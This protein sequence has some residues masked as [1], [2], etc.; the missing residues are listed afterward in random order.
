[1]DGADE[2]ESP[3]RLPRRRRW[4][5]KAAGFLAAFPLLAFLASNLWLASAWG[6]G[7]MAAKVKGVT[8]LETRIAGASWSPWNGI[9][10]H[11]IVLE[12][13]AALRDPAATPLVAIES[14]RI[15]P[16]W[17]SWIHR[18][19]ELKSVEIDRPQ[20]ILPVEL[21]AHLAGSGGPPPATGPAIA[22]TPAP[23]EVPALVPTVPPQEAPI[24]TPSVTVIPPSTSSPEAPEA[25]P[26]I[27]T[28]T[29]WVNVRNASLAL[30]SAASPDRWLEVTGL[31][32][33]VPVA[34]KAA[35]AN[36]V[37]GT[38]STLGH[39][40]AGDL[41]M[42]LRWEP[43]FLLCG[44]ADETFANLK[45]SL[46]AKFA[47][48]AEFPFLIGME[49]PAPQEL[50]WEDGALSAS[51]KET[52]LLARLLG[53]LAKPSSWQGD[54]AAE[55]RSFSIHLP[56]SRTILFDRVSA[57]VFLRQ[58]VLHC[59]DAR[60]IGEELSLL[61]NAT[62]LP[63]GRAALVLRVVTTPQAAAGIAAAFANAGGARANFRPLETPDRLAADFRL[64]AAE[65]RFL[66]QL[67]EGGDIIEAA[68]ALAILRSL[69]GASP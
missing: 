65:G 24:G 48:A 69:A 27:T 59:P 56:D 22:T 44:P 20:V 62:L 7:W 29:A 46:G 50:R 25:A 11:G 41:E 13:P 60:G 54:F 5:L 9:R 19:W 67:G 26:E 23:A 55:G 18:R 2:P 16:V 37:I 17:R 8:T 15:H 63:D 53:Q 38:I 68:P 45:L 49:T 1:M 47:N 6:R 61:G 39:R 33:D 34:G 28:E 42:P 58:G 12:R 51:G 66:V 21:L 30:V 57:A 36:A 64:S 32:A 3:A 40:L 31:T 10:I 14:M 35:G 43:P 52:R 4:R